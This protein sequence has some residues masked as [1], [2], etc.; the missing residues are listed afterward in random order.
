LYLDA[1]RDQLIH[2]KLDEGDTWEV[3]LEWLFRGEEYDRIFP[4]HLLMP[5]VTRALWDLEIRLE[6]QAHVRLDLEDLP[7][8]VTRS[9]CAPIGV[10][11]E[12]V[13]TLAPR[14]GIF[15]YVS[16]LEMVGQ[17]QCHAHADRTQS[18]VYR[19]LGDDAVVE[20]YGLLFSSLLMRPEWL[21]LRLEAEAT[22]D[23][24]RL[25]AF[26]RLYRLRR[27]AASHLYEVELRKAD[28]PDALENE[29]VDRLADAL[30]V[31]PF[32]EHFLD[33]TDETFSG[34]RHLRAALFAAQ[35]GTF[36]EQEID[37]EWYRSVRAGRFLIDRWREGQRYTA[38][39]LA[40][41]L[42]FAGLDP[43][44]LVEELRT[45]LVG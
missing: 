6:D 33:V 36:L 23:A 24:I 41:F 27:A 37:E 30:M 22:R 34:A 12:I 10:P 35:L 13:A 20:S 5:A 28:E 11:D 19:R 2:H 9:F 26:E 38:E 25:R 14:G 43:T 16:L 18:I 29:Y 44:P 32:P 40:R 45:G 17:A 21:T 3:D 39:E 7:G 4:A 15:D 42:G 31:R 8:R 1:L